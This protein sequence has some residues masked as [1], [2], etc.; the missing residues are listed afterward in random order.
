MYVFCLC[1]LCTTEND[2]VVSK[3]V[4]QDKVLGMQVSERMCVYCV[5]V[6]V[7]LCECVFSVCVCA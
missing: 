6:S 1:G 7:C 5:C 3:K 4:M 2:S